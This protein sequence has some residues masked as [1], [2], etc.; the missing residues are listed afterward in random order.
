MLELKAF[1]GTKVK[2]YIEFTCN[3]IKT[4]VIHLNENQFFTVGNVTLK[5]DKG[6]LI[7]IDPVEQMFF[8]I[9]MKINSWQELSQTK[10]KRDISC[11]KPIYIWL[12]CNK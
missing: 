6:I 1:Q 7:R 10:L 3:S 11:Y 8:C 5:Q 12:M 4:A 2:G 9:L